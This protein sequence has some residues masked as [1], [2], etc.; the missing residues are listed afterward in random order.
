[1]LSVHC[2]RNRCSCYIQPPPLKTVPESSMKQFSSLPFSASAHHQ[3][4]VNDLSSVIHQPPTGFA[5]DSFGFEALELHFVFKPEAENNAW[6]HPHR[7]GRPSTALHFWRAVKDVMR[8]LTG[9]GYRGSYAAP[10]PNGRRNNTVPR[11]L[12]HGGGPPPVLHGGGVAHLPSRQPHLDV[13]PLPPVGIPDNVVLLPVPP[14]HASPPLPH[15]HPA[16]ASEPP[17]V[18]KRLPLT[19]TAPIRYSQEVQFQANSDRFVNE[20]AARAALRDVIDLMHKY[21]SVHVT[22]LG[23]AASSLRDPEWPFGGNRAALL[24]APSHISEFP[25]I[26]SLMQGRARAIAKLLISRGISLSRVHYDIGRLEYDKDFI[27]AA[28]KRRATIII[29]DRRH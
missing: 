10:G 29:E 13:P 5:D 19:V 21:P 6:P 7:R 9:H 2:S 17:I 4:A 20:A 8:T 26:G 27:G 18:F 12:P 15:K 24:R 14:H 16:V 3:G 1:M 23:N 11:P 28:H 25:S 22:I